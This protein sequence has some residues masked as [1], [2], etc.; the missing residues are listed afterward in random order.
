[1]DKQYIENQYRL[2]VLDFQLSK[3]EDDQWQS[4]KQMADLEH[5]A[6]VLFGF[7]YA[8]ELHEKMTKDIK[9]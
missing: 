9:M 4:R 1:M 3:S 8:D 6:S 5:T 2:A 7:A